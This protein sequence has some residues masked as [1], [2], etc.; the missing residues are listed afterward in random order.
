MECFLYDGHNDKES[1]T[2]RCFSLMPLLLKLHFFLKKYEINPNNRAIDD[3][4]IAFAMHNDFRI[5][6]I[7]LIVDALF[8]V[9][10]KKLEVFCQSIINS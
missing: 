6:C 9:I 4:S 2:E 7:K 10:S 8:E 1:S 3:K 5:K